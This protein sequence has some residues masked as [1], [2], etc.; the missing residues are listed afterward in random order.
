VRRTEGE[1]HEHV[2][3]FTRRQP[4]EGSSTKMF[5]WGR[6]NCRHEIV[7]RQ[8]AFTQFNNASDEPHRGDTFALFDSGDRRLLDADRGSKILLRKTP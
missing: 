2:G 3:S 5:W 1:K 7:G 4:R 6:R 8:F